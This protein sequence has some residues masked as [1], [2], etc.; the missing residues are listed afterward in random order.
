MNTPVAFNP[1]ARTM[2]ATLMVAVALLCLITG[3]SA[4]AVDDV[5]TPANST[6]RTASSGEDFTG[7]RLVL[8]SNIYQLIRLH[9]N[10]ANWIALRGT[11]LRVTQDQTV[12][13]GTGDLLVTVDT[14]PC[15]IQQLEGRLSARRDRTHMGVGGLIDCPTDEKMIKQM[16][17]VGDVYKIPK[18]V[19]VQY[20][21]F[22]SGWVYGALLVPYKYHLDDKSFSSA[23]TIGPYLGYRMGGLGVETAFI[24]SFGLSSLSVANPSGSGDTSTIQGFSAA[25]GLIGGVSKSTGPMRFGIMFGKD[26]AGSNS[27]VPYKHEGKT[28]VAVQI[29]FSFSE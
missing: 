7:D 19:L 26:W 20:G 8:K 25:I 28:W 24:G 15:I 10:S 4:I 1:L 18:D 11:I 22:R 13:N 21:Y 9:D 5:Q 2:R 29:G 16:V 27:A 6:P 23:T 3:R 14:V 12:G 17:E